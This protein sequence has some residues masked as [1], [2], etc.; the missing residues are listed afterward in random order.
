MH[1]PFVPF[2][3]CPFL[4]DLKQEVAVVELV[5]IWRQIAAGLCPFSSCALQFVLSQ[6]LICSLGCREPKKHPDNPVVF[7]DV[8]IAGQPSG[9]HSFKCMQLPFIHFYAFIPGRVI[10][11]LYADVVPKTA[12]NFRQLCTGEFKQGLRSRMPPFDLSCLICI[13]V[14]NLS[15]SRI[16]LSTE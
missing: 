14:A 15:A 3:C 16:V 6:Q 13:Q 8:S 4:W 10:M 11:E 7:F 12:E 9:K 5:L 1:E 2:G